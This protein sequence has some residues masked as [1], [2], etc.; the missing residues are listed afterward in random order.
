MQAPL[1][2]LNSIS[3]VWSFM[4]LISFLHQA[5]LFSLHLDEG[6]QIL[7]NTKNYPL[8]GIWVECTNKCDRSSQEGN[9]VIH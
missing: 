3:V 1:R 5:F 2:M 9:S 4:R 7:K 6:A 8:A